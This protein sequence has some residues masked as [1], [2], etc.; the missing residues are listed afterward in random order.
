MSGYP[1]H[2][3]LE[4]R[5]RAKEEAERAL[6]AASH[7]LARAEAR[8]AEV[9]AQLARSRSERE[10]R[11]QAQL[12]QVLALGAEAGALSLMRA[13]VQRLEDAEAEQARAL[14][15]CEEEVA[16]ARRALERSRAQLTE[17]ARELEVLQKH[18]EAW[19]QARRAQREVREEQAQEE[20]ASALFLSRKRQ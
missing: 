12:S 7:T 5:E 10:A 15:R 9:E 16:E 11:V 4:L 14:Q 2:T 3:L 6:A 20:V 8:R 18:H 13:H 19:L 1:L 17:A